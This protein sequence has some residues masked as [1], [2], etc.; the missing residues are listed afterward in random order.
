MVQTD[1]DDG[2]GL[3]TARAC[4]Q[5]MQTERKSICELRLSAWIAFG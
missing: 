3:N 5:D 1:D 4:E 2:D